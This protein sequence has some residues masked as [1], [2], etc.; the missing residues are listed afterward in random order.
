GKKASAL[1]Y[2][3]LSYSKQ[4]SGDLAYNI[5]ILLAGQIKSN[6]AAAEE[7]IQY[8]LDAAFLSK[9]NTKKAMDLAQGLFFN[10][11]HKD[12]KYNEKVQE[13]VSR[14]NKITDLSNSFNSK[15]GDKDE[16]DL[17]DTEKKEMETIL[18]SIE[19]EKKA[20]DRLELETKAALEKFNQA[21]ES[22][23]KRLGI[24]Q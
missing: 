10:R 20:I 18:A 21:I 6:P 9:T 3:K 11:A 19:T 7:A 15:F 4:K 1:K 22:A 12:L 8:L 24:V 5:G 14:G 13:L 2:Y 16:E 17:T 23:K